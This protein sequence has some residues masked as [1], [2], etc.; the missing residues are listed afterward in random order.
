[1]GIEDKT[2]R[3][4][5]AS[6]V[7]RI[8]EDERSRIARE[9]HDDTLQWL[10]ELRLRLESVIGSFDDPD[11][12]LLVTDLALS[13]DG[14]VER[15]RQLVFDLDPPVGDT[16]GLAAAI[17]RSMWEIAEL[18]GVVP[19]L[20]DRLE[21]LQ[22]SDEARRAIFRIVKEALVNVR[23]HARAR[24]VVIALEPH[25]D[26]ARVSVE[27]DGRG[28]DDEAVAP[29]GHLGLRSMHERAELAGGWL[30]VRSFPGSGTTIECWVPASPPVG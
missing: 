16:A 25:E 22:L 4:G 12:S 8:R 27:D 19:H 5:E 15:L 17:R 3:S 6:L 9:I 18:A 7:L 20:D 30:R 24:S 28:F 10:A 13:F 2:E 1:V 26:G 29:H 23:R 21:G 14:A 11:R